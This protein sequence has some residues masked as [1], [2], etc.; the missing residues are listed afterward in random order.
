MAD[1]NSYRDEA[2]TI[3]GQYLLKGYKMLASHCL[4]CGVS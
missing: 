4:S 2:A 1:F 3:M